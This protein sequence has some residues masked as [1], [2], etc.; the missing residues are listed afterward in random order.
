MDDLEFRRDLYRGTARYAFHRLCREAVAASVFRS[1]LSRAALGGL[2]AGF[3]EDLRRELHACEPT[4]RLRQMI[5][6]AYELARRPE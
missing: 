1:V 6:F 3:D 4:G 2:A 5:G